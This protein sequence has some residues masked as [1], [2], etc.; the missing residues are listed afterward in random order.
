MSPC[1]NL[2]ID[3]DNLPLFVDNDCD[4]LAESI[5]F[6]RRTEKQAQVTPRI[7]KKREV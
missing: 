4:T 1:A 5:R 7:H 6:I 2:F 3:L